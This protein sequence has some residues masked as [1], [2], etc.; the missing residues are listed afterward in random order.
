MLHLNALR[1]AT[2]DVLKRAMKEPMLNDFVL[3]GGTGLALHYGHRLSDDIDLFTPV[4]F[5]VDIFW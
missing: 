5:D 1:P 2:L 3:V 4:R